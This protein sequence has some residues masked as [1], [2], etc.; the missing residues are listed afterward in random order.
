MK[1]VHSETMRTPWRA[2]LASF[3]VGLAVMVS[4]GCG[5]KSAE[6]TEQSSGGST[7]T[8]SGAGGSAATSN[9]NG[10]DGFTMPTSSGGTSATSDAGGADACPVP[11]PGPPI[12]APP[13]E[14]GCF[15]GVNG[16]WQKVQCFCDFWVDS[17]TTSESRAKLSLSVVP[18][19]DAA[20]SGDVAVNVMFPDAEASW[21]EVWQRQAENTPGFAVTHAVDGTTTVR[22]SQSAVTLAPVPLQA[23]ESRHAHATVDAPSGATV[24][25]QMVADLADDSGNPLTKIS[26][27]CSPIHPL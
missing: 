25:L 12:P 17:S 9:A 18:N 8:L 21:F 1:S 6:A 3:G 14:L 22:L 2:A 19:S 24:Q 16:R 5:G 15:E 10:G 23:C 7:T 4:S 13:T 20:L 27:S 11:E 26:G